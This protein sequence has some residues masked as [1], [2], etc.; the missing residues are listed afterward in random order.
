MSTWTLKEKSCGDLNV[1]LEGDA[2]KAAQKKAFRFR[3]IFLSQ[4]FRY[5]LFL[6]LPY[7]YR[8]FRYLRQCGRYEQYRY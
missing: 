8:L 2:W 7:V 1:V 5:A 4:D 3:R 6:L